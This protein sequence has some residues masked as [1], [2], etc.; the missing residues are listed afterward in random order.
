[1]SEFE[2]MTYQRIGRI[3]Y[4]MFNRPQALNAVNDQFVQDIDDALLEFDI[5]E[6]AW[7]CIM[8]GAGRS[9]CAGADISGGSG[10]KSRMWRG[11]GGGL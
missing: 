10:E 1:M 6:E 9:F 3:G 4:L 2:T 8:H 5:D 11:M 7:V